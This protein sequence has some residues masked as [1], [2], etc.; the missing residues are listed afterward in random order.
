[1]HT[2]NQHA[3]EACE[4]VAKALAILDDDPHLSKHRGILRSALSQLQTHPAPDTQPMDDWLLVKVA[5]YNSP[6]TKIEIQAGHSWGQ[7]EVVVHTEVVEEWMDSFSSVCNGTVQVLAVR[8]PSF[9]KKTDTYF[10]VTLQAEGM[11]LVETPW[12]TT[13]DRAL[14]DTRG[15]YN[16]AAKAAHA[17]KEASE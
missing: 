5:R 16:A 10:K 14:S 12:H 8:P 17:A 15:L 1:M 13:L 7:D 3:A 11:E 9:S 6:A 4:T 2:N